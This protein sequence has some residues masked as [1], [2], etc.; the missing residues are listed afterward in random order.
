METKINEIEFVA[1]LQVTFIVK[2]DD[3]PAYFDDHLPKTPEELTMFK[4][5]KCK[6]IAN[7]VKA[8][9]DA[10]DV[11]TIDCKYFEKE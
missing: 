8:A 6:E 11:I 1:N 2:R 10:D 5:Q 4:E 9:V 3:D 7:V